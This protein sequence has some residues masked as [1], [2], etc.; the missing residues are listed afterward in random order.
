[1]AAIYAALARDE[2]RNDLIFDDV[3]KS[4]E[5]KR[6]PIVLTERKDHLDYF[7]NRFSPFVSNLAVLRGGMSAA[8][9]KSRRSGAARARRSGTTDPGDWPLYRRR[10][11]TIRGSIRC[12]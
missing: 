1:M 10:A 3:L 4:L 11:S 5:A 2:R 9:R 12:S 7:H 6:S 8:E